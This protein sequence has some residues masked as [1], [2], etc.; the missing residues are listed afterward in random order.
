[1]FACSTP[2]LRCGG[3]SS[4]NCGTIQLVGYYGH[5]FAGG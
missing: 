2:A 3:F 4:M 1:M 5:A